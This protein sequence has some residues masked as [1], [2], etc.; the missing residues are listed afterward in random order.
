MVVT[1]D[2]LAQSHARLGEEL[3]AEGRVPLW[4]AFN[5]VARQDRLQGL[6][7]PFSC[8]VLPCLRVVVLFPRMTGASSCCKVWCQRPPRQVA[9]QDQA[10]SPLGLA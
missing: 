9:P 2:P 7:L 4:L 1:N 6:G 8:P 10:I 3:E 5:Q